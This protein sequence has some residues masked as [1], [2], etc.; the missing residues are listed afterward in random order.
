MPTEAQ[1]R[2]IE[3]VSSSTSAYE[4]GRIRFQ[5]LVDGLDLIWSSLD[6]DEEWMDDFRA[7]WFTLETILAITIDEEAPTPWAPH[8]D[9]LVAGALRA[10]RRLCARAET[11][12]R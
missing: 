7:E 8:H 4:A 9:D 2:Q 6:L 5:T 12:S 11:L 3:L 10:F 1:R